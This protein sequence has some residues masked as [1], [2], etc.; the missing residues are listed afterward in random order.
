MER[1]DSGDWVSAYR[2]FEVNVVRDRGWGRKT[3]DERVKN[4]LVELG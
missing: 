2:S 3:W 4:H 1:K